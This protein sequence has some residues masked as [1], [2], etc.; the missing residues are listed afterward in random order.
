[1]NQHCQIACNPPYTQYATTESKDRLSIL[2][3]LRGSAPRRFRLNAEAIGYLE[4]AH[5][6]QITRERLQQLPWEL[7]L[8]EATFSRLLAEALP[9]VGSHQRKWIEDALAITA[10][11]AQTEWPVIRLLL[12]DDAPQWTWLTED[13]ALCWVYGGH[14]YKKLTPWVAAH[15]AAV[16]NFLA[17]FWASM[18]NCWPTGSSRARPNGCGW[19]PRLRSCL[20]PQEL[21]SR[22]SLVKNLYSKSLIPRVTR[23]ANSIVKTILS[24]K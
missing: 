3:V 21:A 17:E 13:L 16:D 1:V 14:Y 24:G 5:L 15:R 9:V 4:Q 7:D 11:H 6:A 8:D 22:I 2:D 23:C 12:G 19:P 18:S 20:R 10:Y